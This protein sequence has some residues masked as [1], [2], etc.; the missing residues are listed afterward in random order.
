LAAV[1]E[2]EYLCLMESMRTDLAADRR[3]IR[4]FVSS[5]FRDMV[6]ERDELMTQTWPELRRRCANSRSSWSR[7]TCAGH[8]RGAEHPQG[9]P[10]A[11]PRTKSESAARSSWPGWASATLDAG[12]RRLHRRPAEEQPCFAVSPAKASR[13][14][15]SCMECS[16]TRRW[17]AARFSTSATRPTPGA[18]R[19]FPRG[20]RRR[21]GQSGG[22]QAIIRRA[23]ADKHIPLREST[24]PR[25]LAALVLHDLKEAIE[26]QS[27]SKISPT[28]SP[29]R[30][31]T[32]RPL[33]NRRRTTSPPD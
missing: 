4:V 33:P 22:A 5:T 12:R 18:R 32:T 9:D 15:K 1:G 17:P 25:T 3:S 10:Q 23:S 26:A 7:W 13:N 20:R 28:R 21:R 24:R 6:E 19:G 16:T 29:A 27:P 30:A 8:C 2:S 14:W 11:L 31:R